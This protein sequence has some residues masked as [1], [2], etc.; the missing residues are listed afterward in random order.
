MNS[1]F[2]LASITV[3]AI[4]YG[5][6]GHGEEEMEEGGPMNMTAEEPPMNMTGNNNGESS[7]E[8]PRERRGV[9][10]DLKK[11][12]SDAV[13]EAEAAGHDAMTKVGQWKDSGDRFDN[14]IRYISNES[15]FDQ[16]FAT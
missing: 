1:L 15:A 3:F 6:P 11:A 4:A 5:F 12:G 13:S 14:F 16:K 7:E 2:F 8:K 10:D 9:S